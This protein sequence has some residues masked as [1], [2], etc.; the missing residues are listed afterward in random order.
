MDT[1]ISIVKKINSK[2][3][4]NNNFVFTFL[5]FVIAAGLISYLIYSVNLHE[6]VIAFQKAD[7]RFITIA[8]ILSVVNVLLQFYK[9]K[10]SC[11]AILNENNNKKIFYSLFYG[12]AAGPFTPVRIGEYLGRALEFKDKSLLSVTTAT[13][14]DKAFTFISITLFG[15]IGSILF[16][17]D[18]YNVNSYLSVSLF[19]IILVLFSVVVMLILNPNTWQNL[20]S[21]RMENSK[22]MNKIYS[23]I[24]LLRELRKRFLTQMFLVSTLFYLF[25]IIQYAV[26]AVAFSQSGSFINFLWAGNMVMFVK[27]IIPQIS[28]ADLGIREGA[29]VFFLSKM[30]QPNSVGFDTSISLF[31]INVLL[32]ALIGLV[33]LIK[34][35][36]A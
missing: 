4:L 13:L 30:G 10:L 25:F 9:W 14:I 2:V 11:K 31:G 35:N 20:F 26:L 21:K 8:L 28:F 33:L 23:Q 29:S 5:K 34:K 32:P 3:K 6:I 22:Y 19:V 24:I 7:Y 15:S 12:F 17:K 18:Y 1:F 36:N 16:L 27:T